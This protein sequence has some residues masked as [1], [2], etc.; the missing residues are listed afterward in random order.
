MDTPPAHPG[1][2]LVGYLMGN[3]YNLWGKT[4]TL[5]VW[6]CSE[7]GSGLSYPYHL[8]GGYPQFEIPPREDCW[9]ERASVEIM[10]M[11]GGILGKFSGV[12]SRVDHAR[13]TFVVNGRLYRYKDEDHLDHWGPSFSPPWPDVQVA[14]LW[15]REFLQPGR[16]I[17]GIYANQGVSFLQTTCGGRGPDALSGPDPVAPP[18]PGH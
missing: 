8:P 5:E 10:D 4:A 11:T 9:S 7:D 2:F 14:D 16:T 1:S 3:I 17:Q 15:A 12:V 6:A 18:C 13:R